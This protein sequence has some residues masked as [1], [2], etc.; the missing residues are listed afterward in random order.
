M[1]EDQTRPA[2]PSRWRHPSTGILSGLLALAVALG[3]TSSASAETIRPRISTATAEAGDLRTE[4]T[5]HPEANTKKGWVKSRFESCVHQPVYLKLLDDKRRLRGELWF[6]LWMLG[7]AYD[8]SRRVDY[9]TSIEN[10]RTKAV[11]GENPD[12]W[13]IGQNFTHYINTSSSSPNAEITK[14]ANTAHS[15]TIAEWTV[16][17]TQ[18]LTYTSPDTG[19]VEAANP[20]IAQGKVTMEM[21]VT[22]PTAAPWVDADMAYSNIR[23]DYT[24][25]AA[26]KYKGTVFTDARVEL[27]MSLKDP[28]VDQSARHILDAQQFPE[29]TFPSW[30]GK[31]VPGGAD[32]PL[33]RLIDSDLQGKN[34]D[35]SIKQCNDVW[36]DYSGT[37]L[38][39]DEYPFAST[40]EGSMKG[41]KRYSVRLIDGDDNREGGLLIQKVYEENRVLD[42][43]PFYVKIVP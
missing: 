11:S 43:D 27:T 1:C 35:N 17:P 19:K 34:R 31:S 7:F 21:N 33:H 10:I 16:N 36:G 37:R 15:G 12:T 41:D 40:R 3:M 28:K 9:V 25:R 32:D 30:P 8:G 18:V 22:S 14:P 13:R 38:E 23:F 39:C 24:G 6:D 42:N 20:Q 2:H 26:G 4:C 5:A 29:R